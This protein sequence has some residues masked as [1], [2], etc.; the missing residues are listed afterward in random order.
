MKALEIKFQGGPVPSVLPL[1][2]PLVTNLK[3]PSIFNCCILQRV[4]IEAAVHTCSPVKVFLKNLKVLQEH[5]CFGVSFQYIF[6]GL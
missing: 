1:D 3:K 6:A 4:F 2:P 5:T